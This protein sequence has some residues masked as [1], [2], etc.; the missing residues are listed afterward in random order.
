MADCVSTEEAQKE[1]KDARF[2]GYVECSAKE[3]K[4]LNKVFHTAFKVVFQLRSLTSPNRAI[5]A[6]EGDDGVIKQN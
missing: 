2:L 3:R 1:A 4:G 5:T 6:V